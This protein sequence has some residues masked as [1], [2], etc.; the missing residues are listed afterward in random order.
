VKIKDLKIQAY[1]T[2]WDQMKIFV[3]S[4]EEGSAQEVLLLEHEPVFTLGVAGKEEH[5][6]INPR[7]IPLV[8]SDRGGQ[9]TYHGPGQLIIYP[10]INL[11]RCGLTVRGYVTQLEQLVIDLLKTYDIDAVRNPDMPGV[12]VDGAKIASIGIRVRRGWTLHGVSLNVNMDLT[13]FSFINPC[14]VAKQKMIRICD[15]V[16][17]IS[18]DEIKARCNSEFIGRYLHERAPNS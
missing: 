2:V 16:P 11:A 13:P 15:F 12:Y 17:G 4:R 9:V 6:L 18:M 8:R 14:G 3:D 10:L 1:Q 5:V 7:N